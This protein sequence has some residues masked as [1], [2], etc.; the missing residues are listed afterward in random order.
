MRMNALSNVSDSPAP[1]DNSTVSTNTL[2][3]NYYRIGNFFHLDDKLACAVAITLLITAFI[4]LVFTC[5]CCIRRLRR[6]HQKPKK[7]GLLATSD[8]EADFL[9]SGMT[10]DYDDEEENHTLFVNSRSKQT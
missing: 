3:S 9:N 2:T 6:R 8:H 10:Y 5:C 7:Y 4:F 1:S